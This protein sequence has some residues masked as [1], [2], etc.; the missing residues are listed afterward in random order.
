MAALNDEFLL[1]L[2]GMD[3]LEDKIFD[4]AYLFAG[5]RWARLNVT[6]APSDRVRM[7]VAV[8]ERRVFAFGGEGPGEHAPQLFDN[9]FELLIDQF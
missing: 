3:T 7:A 5:D 4:D 9:L 8:S 1:L 6:D 2:G